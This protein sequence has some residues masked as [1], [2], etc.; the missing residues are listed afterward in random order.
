MYVYASQS[1]YLLV[2][3]NS[4][5]ASKLQVADYVR[6]TPIMHRGNGEIVPLI[7]ENPPDVSTWTFKYQAVTYAVVES[8][9]TTFAPLAYPCS[10]EPLISTL[11]RFGGLTQEEV[12]QRTKKFGTNELPIPIPTFAQLFLIHLTAPLAIYQAFCAILLLS[13]AEYVN[14]LLS[15]LALVCSESMA[16]RKVCFS[17]CAHVKAPVLI[18]L[19]PP[20]PAAR[21]S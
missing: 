21:G 2:Y 9:P 1:T 7:K 20:P 11:L 5:K 16:V 17:P 15:L 3:A 18:V 14:P 13:F 12:E 8:H 10:D 6:I 19:I 4:P